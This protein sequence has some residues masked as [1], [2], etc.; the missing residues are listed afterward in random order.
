MQLAESRFT[1]AKEVDLK[2]ADVSGL[3]FLKYMPGYERVIIVDAADMNEKPCAIK[4]FDAKDIKGGSFKDC[5]STHGIS[6]LDTLTLVD[7]LG[8]QSKITI[9]GVQPK[10]VNF[11]LEPTAEIKKTVPLIVSRIKE[12]LN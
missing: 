6:L 9:V 8:I 12:A 5:V 4:V 7:R 10:D 2:A 3:D 11:G 1:V